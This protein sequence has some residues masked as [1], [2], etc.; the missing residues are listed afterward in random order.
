MSDVDKRVDL[1]LGSDI[2]VW[3]LRQVEARDVRLVV[4]ED[5]D[6]ARL[7]ER[8]G[9]TA[10]SPPAR[11][12]RM[13]SVHYPEVLSAEVLEAYD[14]AWNLHPG[15]LP[16]GRGHFPLVWSIWN[17]EPAGAT[18]HRMVRRVD[19]GPIVD[20]IKVVVAES[21]TAGSLH[22]RIRAAERSLFRRWWPKI[23]AGDDIPDWQPKQVGSY[24]DKAAFEELLATD[25]AHLAGAD[26][27]RL[28]RALSFPG[29]PGLGG[30]IG[31]FEPGAED[32]C[33]D[34]NRPMNQ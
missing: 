22:K 17:R 26:L 30:S 33:L 16:W 1:Y 25:P 31:R 27:D 10:S 29:K 34:R 32:R 14:G 2:G 20:Q 12:W 23:R 13:L 24:H 28:R 18:L 15:Y 8:H 4:S 3:V 6:I 5:V 11:G 19:A 21:D 9:I 7:A